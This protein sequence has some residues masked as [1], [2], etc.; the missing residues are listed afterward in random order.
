VLWFN[1]RSSFDFIK[2]GKG[3]VVQ[4]QKFFVASS[5]E[6]LVTAI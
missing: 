6:F 4:L 1:Y 2:V 3:V 5:Q